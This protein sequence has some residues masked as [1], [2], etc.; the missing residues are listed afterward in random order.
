MLNMTSMANQPQNLWGWK[1]RYIGD[2]W[3]LQCPFCKHCYESVCLDK[4]HR[5][6]CYGCKK[7][8]HRNKLI[9]IILKKPMATCRVC[10][11]DVSLTPENLS[12]MGFYRCP[13]PMTCNNIVAIRFKN[14]VL[15]PQTIIKLEWNTDIKNRAISLG[16]NLFCVVCTSKK[17]LAVLSMLRVMAMEEG[18][19][20]RAF[21]KE[22]QKSVILFDT[23]KQKYLGF[24]VWSE[25]KNAVLRQIFV[26]KDEQRRGYGTN[27]LKFWVENFADGVSDNF[28]VESANEKTQGLLLKL[29]YAKREDG[30]I[31]GIKCSFEQGM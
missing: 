14:Y 11:T 8:T 21:Y 26:I 19:P 25:N 7:K 27:F 2:V 16:N 23:L 18:Q 4:S 20:F 17:D 31:K 30:F 24:I 12:G 1:R 6:T 13:T 22:K 9:E 3:H 10:E 5:F 28:G 29:G 15:Q